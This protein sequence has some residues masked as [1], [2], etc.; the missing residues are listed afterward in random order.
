MEEK[1]VKV[2]P[3]FQT[4][5][6]PLHPAVAVAPHTQKPNEQTVFT[7]HP[8]K[9]PNPLFM[10]LPSIIPA[11]PTLWHRSLLL[12][13]FSFAQWAKRS[14]NKH[15]MSRLLLTKGQRPTGFPSHL[16]DRETL[17]SLAARRSCPALQGSGRG[18][19]IFIFPDLWVQP[20]KRFTVCAQHVQE[21]V[22]GRGDHRSRGAASAGGALLFS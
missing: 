8:I 15:L 21:P 16:E 7:L 20:S 22:R 12:L 18:W 11:H 17:S 13:Q 14:S 4:N 10:V 6:I 3:L 2:W 5:T 19:R 9:A 1:N